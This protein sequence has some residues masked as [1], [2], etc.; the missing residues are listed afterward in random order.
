MRALIA[1][2]LVT[3]V[4]GQGAAAPAPAI[5][6]AP[7]AAAA[8]AAEAAPPAEPTPD[9]SRIIFSSNRSG[10]WRLWTIRPDGSDLKP[11]TRAAEGEHDVDPAF[12]PD[13]RRILFTSTRGGTTGVWTVAADGSG[14][15]RVADGDQAEWAP[16]GRRI[17]L[18]RGGRIVVRT[19]ADG[20]E[21]T[22]TPDGWTTCSGPA[23]SP[24]GKTLAFARL[25][26][27]ANAVYTLPADG[28][29][30]ALVVGDRG[31]CEPHFS[32]DGKTI[33]YET[34]THLAAVAPDG[35]K[36]RPVTW[37]G[38]VQ[39][40]GRFSP[41]GRHIVFCQAPGPEG[42]WELYVIPAA[43]GPSRKLTDGGSDMHPDWK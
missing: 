23:F 37:F 32:P 5:E 13:G 34:E 6:A 15:A 12:S 35:S 9:A 38:G 11:L 20:R 24:D 39:R 26:D 3:A 29:E 2:I 17:V 41:D 8:S 33:L 22:V 25:R 4:A 40:Y 18:R 1:A 21:T 14:A 30:P 36:N 43:G 16:D 10:D 31:A 28:G 7:A 42:P 27:G 19:L